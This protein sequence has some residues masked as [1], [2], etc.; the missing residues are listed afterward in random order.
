[1]FSLLTG[2]KTLNK[3]FEISLS[4]SFLLHYPH[5]EFLHFDHKKQKTKTPGGDWKIERLSGF[6][7]QKREFRTEDNKICTFDV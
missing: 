7:L 6:P 2:S 3:T 1:M 4:F 5:E